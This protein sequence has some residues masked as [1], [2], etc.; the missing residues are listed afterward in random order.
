MLYLVTFLSSIPAVALLAPILNR[1]SY[2][3]EHGSDLRVVVG[4]LLDVVNALACVGTAVA[5]YAVT[6][7]HSRT[8]PVG[9]LASRLIEASIILVGVVSLLGVLTL[10]REVGSDGGEPLVMAGRALLA[11]RDWTFVLGPGLM[12]PIN[13]LMLAPVLLR[14]RI[15]PAWIPR[16]G[17]LGAALLLPATLVTFFHHGEPVAAVSLIGVAPIFV[18]ELSLGLWLALRGPLHEAA[19]ERLGEGPRLAGS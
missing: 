19:D 5:F 1:N 11:V 6:R 9:F 8:L 7:R 16:L 18:W 15:V 12:A 2:V 17:L 13:A 4:C 14:A 3:L 10:R